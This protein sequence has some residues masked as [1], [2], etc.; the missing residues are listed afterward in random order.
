MSIESRLLKQAI[1]LV[2]HSKKLNEENTMS[3]TPEQE[4]LFYQ[5][6]YSYDNKILKSSV[7]DWF[8]KGMSYYSK[9][10]ELNEVDAQHANKAR[11]LI[12]ADVDSYLKIPAELQS[13]ISEDE[14]KELAVDLLFADWVSAMKEV[15]N[16]EK[17]S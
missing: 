5:S 6:L 16:E 13:V 3:L 4:E 15:I 2:E 8:R 9:H 14:A 17:E 7:N 10:P 1:K 12:T 11:S